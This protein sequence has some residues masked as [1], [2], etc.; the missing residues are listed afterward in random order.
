MSHKLS[1]DAY[2]KLIDE[3]LAWLAAQPRTLERDH[4]IEIVKA[5]LNHEYP[6]PTTPKE[7]DPWMRRC[8]YCSMM[9]RITTAGC[10]HC[11]PEDK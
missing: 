11:E 4:I 6:P 8:P 7:S 2:K 3:D 10:D 5:S 1:P 9:T